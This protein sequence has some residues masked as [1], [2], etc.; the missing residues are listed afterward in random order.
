MS[1]LNELRDKIH[2]TAVDKGW[3]D[4]PRE[5]GTVIALIHSELSEALEEYRKGYEPDHIYCMHSDITAPHLEG[6]NCK[7]EGVPIE[8]VD[9]IIRILDYCGRA[10]I[11]VDAAME[12][13][14]TYNLSRAYRHGGKV[15]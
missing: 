12:Y 2:A 15:V 3:W 6:T 1:E 9:A 11:D 14:L 5:F 13:K 10:G 7:P 8:L 4:Q